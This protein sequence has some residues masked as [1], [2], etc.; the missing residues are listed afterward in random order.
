[1]AA[2]AGNQFWK[3]RSKHGRDKL[4]STPE[5]LWEACAEY[6]NWCDA[7]PWWKNEAV[8][9]GDM[10]G[11]II[12]VPIARPYTLSG[13]CVYLGASASFWKDLKNNE[14]LSED[15]SA[16]ITRVDEIMYTQ[17]FEGAAVGAFNANI[18]ARDLGLREKQDVDVRTPEGV[19]VLYKQQAGNQ[20]LPDD[21]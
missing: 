12:K 16:V 6:F 14:N 4:F 13:L 3:L 2:P 18:I 9:S 20:P 17:K 8:K 15:F 1:M 7:H 5:L 10:A 21:D 19:T 11:E